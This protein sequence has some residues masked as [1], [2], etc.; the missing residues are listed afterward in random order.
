[1]SNS[2]TGGRYLWCLQ[3]GAGQVRWIGDGPQHRWRWRSG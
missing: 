1:M 2:G 3:P